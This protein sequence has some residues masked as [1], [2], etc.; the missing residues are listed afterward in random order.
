MENQICMTFGSNQI[1]NKIRKQHPDVKLS[2]F[3]N[4]DDQY[5]IVDFSGNHNIFKN[6]IT[7]DVLKNHNFTEKFEF[8]NY[9]YF[10]LSEDDQKIFDASIEKMDNDAELDNMI[11]FVILKETVNRKRTVL[12]TTWHDYFDFNN[13]KKR[14]DFLN[15]AEM[16]LNYKRA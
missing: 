10:N 2:L 1:L 13:W 6:P 9:S 8:V 11:S 7:F 12:M 14:N 16:S 5:Q 15:L 3:K 4:G